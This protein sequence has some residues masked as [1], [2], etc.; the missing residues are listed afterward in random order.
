MDDKVR[1]VLLVLNPR[2]KQGDRV[3]VKDTIQPRL[4]Y[5]ETYPEE[6][7]DIPRKIISYHLGYN[8]QQTM[9][10]RTGEIVV[11][12]EDGSS[13]VKMSGDVTYWFFNCDLI[14]LY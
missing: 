9:C 8:G 6:V 3:R 11:A 14:K 12:D 10:G 4:V 7:M 5:D 13:L 2:L 1:K